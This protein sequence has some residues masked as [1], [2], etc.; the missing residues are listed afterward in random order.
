MSEETKKTKAP[1][2]RFPQFQN[3]P[4][5]KKRKLLEVLNE[6]G[7]KSEGSEEVFS[8]S[9]HKGVI[10]QKE[11]LGRSFSA[12]S[13]GHY[14]RVMP[15][16]VIYTKSPTG[17]FPYGIIKQSRHNTPIIV[18]PLYGVFTP[19]TAALGYILDAYFE[20]PANAHNYLASIVQKGAKNT[21]NIT[22]DTFLSKALYLPSNTDEQ[23][24]IA[25]F[26]SSL[27]E[28]ISAHTQKLEA[29]KVHKTGLMQQLF[30][31]EGETVPRLRFAEFR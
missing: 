21:I 23:K 2:L 14:N 15:S 9:V 13:T 5:W 26:L 25:D 7:S 30:P 28:L 19:E 3:E 31:A 18:S 22:N 27:D 6:H 8:V 24:K 1:K 11:H 10:N 17:D 4:E 29:L 20:A 12:A 16:D